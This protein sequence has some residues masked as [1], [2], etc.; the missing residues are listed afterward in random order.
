MMQSLGRDYVRYINQTYE[1][2]GALW[3]GRYKSTS[4]GSD[5]YFLTTSRYIELNPARAG[6]VAHPAGSLG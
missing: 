3:E 2:T 5:N 4:V 6:M 1:R